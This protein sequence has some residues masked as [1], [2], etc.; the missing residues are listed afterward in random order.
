VWPKVTHASYCLVFAVKNCARRV[1]RPMT[2]GRT[3]VASGSSVP[4]VTDAAGAGDASHF[5]HDVVRGASFAF[6]DHDDSVQFHALRVTGSL[7]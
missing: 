1:A 7:E 2:S 4:Q 3:P 6:V 5:V